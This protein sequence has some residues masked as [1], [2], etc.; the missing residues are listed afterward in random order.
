MLAKVNNFFFFSGG[1]SAAT[2][3][4]S[5]SQCLQSTTVNTESFARM[6]T[7][8]ILTVFEYPILQWFGQ[9]TPWCFFYFREMA[10]KVLGGDLDKRLLGVGVIWPN[11]SLVPGLSQ[12]QGV[13]WPNHPPK[14]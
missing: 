2:L 4:F 10:F 8:V 5:R 12:H 3:V 7:D 9:M 11:Y 14:L 1:L 6:V 13:F